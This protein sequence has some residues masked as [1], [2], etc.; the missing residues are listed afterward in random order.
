MSTA[1]T[2]DI[3][4]AAFWSDPYPDLARLRPPL[5]RQPKNTDF[6]SVA[7]GGGG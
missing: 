6:K 5:G 3:D 2:F 4:P 7:G 1:P